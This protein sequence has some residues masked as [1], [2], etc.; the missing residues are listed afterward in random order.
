MHPT[1]NGLLFRCITGLGPGRN[2]NG[3]LGG[4][5]FSGTQIPGGP[6]DGPGIQS[7][8]ATITNFVGAIN[9]WLCEEFTA[10]LEGVYTCNMRNSSMLYQS[11]RVGVYFASRSRLLCNA[12]Y[13]TVLL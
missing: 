13:Y 10:D 8:G 5:Y 2:S 1:S 11:M 7:R 9:I 3:E 12:K 6:C 4:L